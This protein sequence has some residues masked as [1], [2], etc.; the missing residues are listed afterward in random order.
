MCNEGH[1]HDTLITSE[2]GGKSL[3]QPVLLPQGHALP[4]AGVKV[5]RG[6]RAD[7]DMMILYSMAC[8][9]CG[10]DGAVPR[11][12][13]EIAFKGVLNLLCRGLWV[14]AQERV[15]GHDDA[16]CTEATLCAMCRSDALL[17]GMW[18]CAVADA[19]HRHNGALWCSG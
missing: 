3:Q 17:N 8:L 14:V 11:A 13:A 7:T 10:Q 12:A 15:H 5:C 4:L 18:Y 6:Q 2:A 1:S 19:L 9:E 16:R